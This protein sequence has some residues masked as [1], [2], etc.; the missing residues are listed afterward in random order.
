L[1]NGPGRRA[2]GNKREWNGDVRRES[3]WR[4]EG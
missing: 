4:V 3:S 1:R 2:T